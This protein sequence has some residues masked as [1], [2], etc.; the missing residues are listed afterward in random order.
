MGSEYVTF[1]VTECGKIPL[2]QRPDSPTRLPRGSWAVAQ[3]GAFGGGGT[4]RLCG[5]AA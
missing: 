4:C 2:I 5:A 3:V 1:Y